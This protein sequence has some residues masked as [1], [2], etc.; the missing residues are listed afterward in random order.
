MSKK[1]KLILAGG[2]LVIAAAVS[3]WMLGQSGGPA[4]D[5]VLESHAEAISKQLRAMEDPPPPPS[6]P[7]PERRGPRRAE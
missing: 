5:P 2:L 6:L 1:T 4:T 7:P 3:I